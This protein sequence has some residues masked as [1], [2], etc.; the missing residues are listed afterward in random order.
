MGKKGVCKNQAGSPSACLLPSFLPPSS[1]QT[2]QNAHLH[3]SQPSQPP[4]SCSLP[5]CL[6]LQQRKRKARNCH[7]SLSQLGLGS[8]SSLSFLLGMLPCQQGSKKRP[9]RP[10]RSHASAPA[11]WAAE[12]AP[13][14]PALGF[15]IWDHQ[16]PV[17]LGEFWVQ[18]SVICI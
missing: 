6:P 4:Y 10:Q 17:S 18:I 13:T 15:L 3:H 8:N 14:P 12:P 16:V 1:Q 11:Q 5:N 7:S 9:N 2:L